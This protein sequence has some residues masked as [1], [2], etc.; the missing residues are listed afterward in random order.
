MHASAIPR[1]E[2]R[3]SR[4]KERRAF[5]IAFDQY[6]Q[7]RKELAATADMGEKNRIFRRLVNLLE[8]MQF[9]NTNSGLPS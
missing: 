7:L 9:L 6:R 4:I 5:E 2:R 1:P 8:V 3:A